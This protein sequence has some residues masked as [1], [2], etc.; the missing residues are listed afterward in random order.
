LIKR[1]LPLL[2]NMHMGTD[3]TL[4]K[5]YN[6][7]SWTKLGL[8]FWGLPKCMNTSV[9]YALF[10]KANAGQP[11]YA[12]DGPNTW[13]HRT[14]ATTYVT[15]SIAMNNGNTNFTVIRHPYDRMVSLYT[16]VR[17]NRR[18]VWN[19]A[20]K[21]VDSMKIDTMDEFLEAYIIHSTDDTSTDIHMRSLTYFICKNGVPL[22][23]NIFTFNT[24]PT[25]LH[26][27]GMDVPHINISKRHDII[28]TPD[29][30]RIIKRRYASEFEIFKD[31]L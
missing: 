11:R 30:K 3:V 2:I 22:F 27:H 29:Q 1:G 13:L 19:K 15:P 12:D 6:I 24:V 18:E 10:N 16:D 14:D 21:D 23:D 5:Q 25:F 4:K 9:K 7:T 20:I 8:N 31:F 28:L 17:Y 26:A